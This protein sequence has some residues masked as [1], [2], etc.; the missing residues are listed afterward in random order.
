MARPF[1]QGLDYFPL[2][3]NTDSKI[4]ILESEYGLLGFGFIVRMFQK[5]YTS[6]YYLEWNEYSPAL[7]K[8]E[9]GLEK[10]TISE[11]I[12]FCSK[13]EIFDK[14]MY[15][16][17]NI[18]TSKGIQKRYFTVSKRRKDIEIIDDYLLINLSDYG[19]TVINN[20]TKNDN[21]RNQC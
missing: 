12:D 5:I 11:M 10:D 16:K 2:D 20:E 8:K 3:T 9:T 6:G 1:K 14:T 4:E 21:E 18:L 7:F 13:I 19:V 17:Y 15:E